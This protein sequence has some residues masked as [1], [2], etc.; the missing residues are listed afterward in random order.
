MTPRPRWNDSLAIGDAAALA[1][2][3]PGRRQPPRAGHLG[4]SEV[5]VHVKSTGHR[6]NGPAIVV[7]G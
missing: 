6:F 7:D 4:G 1:A 2:A 3:S 5:S